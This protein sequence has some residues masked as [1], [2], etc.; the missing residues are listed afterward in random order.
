M[1][2]LNTTK[3]VPMKSKS[4][5]NKRKY[6][7]LS[8]LIPVFLLLFI[9]I[10]FS[11]TPFGNRTWLTVDLGQQY[12]DFFAY[13]QDTLLHHPEQFF[14]SFSKSI[15]GEM[16]SLWSYYLLS[17][18]NLIFLMIPK[19]YITMGVSLLIFLKL[20]F[21]TVSFAYFLDKQFGKRN[22]NALLF[23]L[24]YGFMSYL[25][26]NQLNIMWL[27]ALIGLPL[28]LLGVDSLINNENPIRYIL[29][30]AITVLANYYTGYMI[31]LFLVFYFPYAYLL[32]KRSFQWKDFLKTGARFAF[33]SILA[34][35]LIMMILLPSA[36]SLLGSKGAAK[37]S[38]W[39]MKS[40]YNPLLILSKLF[41]GSFDFQQ[42]PKGYPNIFV[43]SLAL[44]SF[45]NYFTHKK[46]RLAEK[47]TALLI[48][49]FFLLSFN[50][51]FLDRIWHAGQL[52]NWYPYRFSFLF[53][54]W[55]VY[56]GYQQTLKSSKIS[57]FEAFTFFFFMLSISIGFIL[58]PQSYLQS[59][60]IVLGF[61]I[62]MGILYGLIAQTRSHMHTRRLWISLVL[63]ELVLNSGINLARLGYVMNSDFTNYQASLDLW[64][65]S[66][67]APDNTFFR[68]EKTIAR[69]KN[70]SLQVPTYGIS[71]FSSTFEKESERFFEAIGVRQGVAF[72]SY[73]NGTLLT[74]ALLGIKTTFIAN[75]QA[76]YNHR[77][78][79]KDLEVLDVV[80]QFE[81]GTVVQNDNVLSIAYPMKPILKA[82]KV[83][84]NQPVVMQNQLSN[85]LA[86]TLSPKNI[87]TRIPSQM[88][89]SNI[90]GRPFAHQTIQLENSEEKGSI[91]LTFTPETD[92]PIYLEL[93]G[94]M[95]EDSFTMTL[96]GKE[97]FFYPVESRPVLLSIASKKK[98]IPQT[99]EFTIQKDQ[100]SFKRLNLYS[101][102]ETLLQD[103]IQQTKAQELKLDTFSSTHFSGTMTVEE[104]S[105]LL[106]TIPYSIGWTVRVDGQPVE[107]YKI[108]DS[109]LG[110]S[111]SPGKHS[112]EYHYTAPYLI[113]GSIISFAS[114]IFIILI[115]LNRRK[116]TDDS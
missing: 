107:T 19:S 102:N 28:I 58:Y 72:V 91:T 68:S 34:I 1:L 96:N 27:D 104:E 88:A 110:F 64:S 41:I 83:P 115:L 114:I 67:S 80:Q 94:D 62:S 82:M 89:Y 38:L 77:W 56:I 7:S 63:I 54:F 48:T 39:S 33:Y 101:L 73:S 24:S 43:G 76:S 26:V 71:H 55:I 106:T 23:S 92:D 31:C 46:I 47:I 86:G 90:K 79:R 5:W 53:S 44:F 42:M 22:I 85:A 17:P 40:E 108:L 36:Y 6:Y 74:D 14:Y 50:I 11:M 59:W 13:Y 65:Q 105:T 99:I 112:V 16:V 15:G 29:P 8:I 3:E 81:E 103:R 70:D 111:I 4:N 2:S 61:G 45:F 95:E 78:E 93:A 32:Q 60:Q 35:G 49:L 12:V 87:F 66:L 113:E 100:F 18:F 75:D 20:I 37:Q 116:K 109:L 57:M 84:V 10:L 97:Y 21:C 98:G 30:L 51:D 9:F 69:S 25:S 52:P